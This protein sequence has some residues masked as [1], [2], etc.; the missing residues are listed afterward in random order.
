[1][2]RIREFDPEN[3]LAIAIQV[4]WEKGYA[5]TSMRDI[6]KTSGIAHAGV[7]KAFGNKRALFI[8]CLQQYNIRAGDVLLRKLEKTDSD[9]ADIHAFFKMVA[10]GIENGKLV[11]GCL[12]GNTVN[13]F[14]SDSVDIINT[15][16]NF[17]QRMTCAFAGA[18]SR[19]HDDGQLKKSKDV[20]ALSQYLTTY[21]YG[22]MTMV[23]AGISPI[24]IQ[25]NIKF[26]MLNLL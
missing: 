21:F 12:I 18:L 20:A 7:Y 5:D 4:F 10:D 8:K 1:M 24:L 26:V 25:Q 23:R 11:N 13:E 22:L 14:G 6:V 2:A 17:I 9:I 15:A 19:S 3:L 16:N